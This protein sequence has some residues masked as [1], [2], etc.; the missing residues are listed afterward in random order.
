MNLIEQ[1]LLAV[2]ILKDQITDKRN[3]LDRNVCL[4][5]DIQ[6]ALSLVFQTRGNRKN[7]LF[8]VHLLD[9]LLDLTGRTD[10]WHTTQFGSDFAGIIIDHTNRKIGDFCLIRTFLCMKDF[11]Q[12]HVGSLSAANNHGQ[13]ILF[14]FV[15]ATADKLHKGLLERKSKQT[16]ANNCSHTV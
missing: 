8:N 11:T 4:C 3:Y 12:E 10:N 15:P 14:G 5:T 7:N 6:N 9:I 16:Y 13:L 1:R 2:C